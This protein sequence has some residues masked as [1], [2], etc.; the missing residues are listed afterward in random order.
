MG[1]RLKDVGEFG[2]IRRIRE[3]LERE[4]PQQPPDCT[5]G[6]G[7]DTAAFIPGAGCEILLTCDSTVEGRHYLTSFLGPRDVGRRAMVLNV[8]DIGAM[9]GRPR[10]ALVSLGLRKD[11]AARDVEEMYRG[12]LEALNP[13]GATV[14]GGNLTAVTHEAFIDITLIGE[15]KQG[16]VV[17]RSTARP[18][19]TILVTGCPG[20]S[21]AGLQLLLQSLAPLHH[22]LA[23]AYIA[24]THRAREGAA[25]ADT[26]RATAMIDTSDGLVGDLGHLCEESGLGAL[27]IE[28][29]LPISKDLQDAA[30]LL[31]KEPQD[32]LLGPSDDYELIITCAGKHVSAIQAAV[33][34]TYEGPVTEVGKMTEAARGMVLVLADGS[35]KPLAAEGWNHFR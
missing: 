24:P 21:A 31:G 20:R 34:S 23:R 16:R 5:V 11:T 29:R 9:G 19:D 3:L 27:L 26:R 15:A 33:K 8:S 30:A 12:F 22:P 6:L 32:F 28:E 25:V 17:R 7:D 10:Y 18:G 4:G 2:L 35:R 1:G 13:F 14:I